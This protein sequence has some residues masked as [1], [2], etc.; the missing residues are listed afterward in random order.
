M[1][2]LGRTLAG[3]GVDKLIAALQRAY[4]DEWFAHYNYELTAQGLRGHFSPA[5]IHLLRR[6]SEVAFQ[7]SRRLASRI[8]EMGGSLIYKLTQLEH[9][10]TD[11]PFKLPDSM[12]DV[13]AVLKAVLDAERTSIRTYDEIRQQSHGRDPLTERLAS[14]YLAAAVRS[15]EELERL[16]GDPALQMTGE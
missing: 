1:G 8:Q 3:S 16:I 13:E 9:H 11:K 14:K 5:T 4:A 2:E 12:A 10:A 7:R 6:K 15:E